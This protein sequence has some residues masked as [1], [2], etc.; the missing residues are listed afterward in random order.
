MLL[1]WHPPGG[2]PLAPQD[3]GDSLEIDDF[4][5]NDASSGYVSVKYNLTSG[6][7][8][9]RTRV[10]HSTKPE[11]A[12][13]FASDLQDVKAGRGIK[14][15]DVR[16]EEDS[17]SPTDVIPADTIEIELVDADGKV[18]AKTAKQAAMVCSRPK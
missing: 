8:R 7:G 14:L 12:S 2:Q 18:V 10:Y 17:K 15:I 5:Q 6:Q 11:S 16:V 3:A 13:Y 1:T 9:I 4:K